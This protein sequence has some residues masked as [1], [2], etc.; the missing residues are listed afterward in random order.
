VPAA[1]TPSVMCYSA[2]SR[3]HHL[4]NMV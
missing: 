4:S 3:Q 1:G 2:S